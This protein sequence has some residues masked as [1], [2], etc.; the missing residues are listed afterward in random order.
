MDDII[1][2][3][4]TWQDHE[5]HIWEVLHCLREAGPTAKPRKCQF[6]MACCSYLGQVVGGGVVRQERT[7][8]E[9]VQKTLTPQ[10]KKQVKA[11]LSLTDYYRR[12]IPDY[13]MIPALLSDLTQKSPPQPRLPGRP[14]VRLPLRV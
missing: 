8:I 6:G 13:A 10:M 3:S 11:F 12:F 5:R 4:K 1:I 9:A 14:S 7:K 2:Y